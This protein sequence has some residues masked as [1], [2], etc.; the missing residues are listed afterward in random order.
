MSTI[1]RRIQCKGTVNIPLDYRNVFVRSKSDPNN[2][3]QVISKTV[4]TGQGLSRRYL[5]RSYNT[6]YPHYYKRY[7]WTWYYHYV[8]SAVG[9][10]IVENIGFSVNGTHFTID[11][12]QAA[13]SGSSAES[14]LATQTGT[15]NSNPG[16][17]TSVPSFESKLVW[18][19]PKPF[20]VGTTV[21]QSKIKAN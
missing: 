20:C 14:V 16:Q 17:P 3:K 18:G 7:D 4:I 19:D 10:P 6:G 11:T 21:I 9:A 1:I 13:A 15:G 12:T 2:T 5:S 8:W